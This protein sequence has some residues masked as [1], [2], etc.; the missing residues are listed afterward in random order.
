MTISIV[1]IS[2]SNGD[3]F[4]DLVAKANTLIDAMNLRTVTVDSNTTI[5]HAAIAGSL[6]TNT[7]YVST[8]TGGFKDNT[9][10]IEVTSNTSFVNVT[11]SGTNTTFAAIGNIR[12]PGGNVTHKTVLVDPATS[13]L[14]Y[15]D[16]RLEIIAIDGTG[17][18]IDSDLLDGQEG[19]WYADIPA[20]Q[21]YVSVNK[22]GD[23]ISGPLTVQG[24]TSLVNTSFTGSNTNFS[25]IGNIRIPGS[26]TTN[27]TV[28]VDPA[29][30]RLR[31]ADLREE[32]VAIDGA[33]SLIDSDLLDGQEGTWYTDIP[34]RQGYI[35]VNRAGDTISGALTVQGATTIANT[36]NIQSTVI[37]ANTT[38]TRIANTS[39]IEFNSSRFLSNTSLVTTVTPTVLHQFPKIAFSTVKYVISITNSTD[40]TSM[41]TE[42][43]VVSNAAANVVHTTQYATIS[44]NNIFGEFTANIAGANTQLTFTSAQTK[45]LTV[46]YTA[47]LVK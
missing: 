38:V 16:L 7:V 17:S 23:I 45:T 2:V 9:A 20:R 18:L 3:T 42:L 4:L 40:N 33:G 47:T 37:S 30:N 6:S 39:E 15:G 28:M 27:K 22:A 1:P 44:T 12:I 46:N 41:A 32:I 11:F 29:T 25:S 43:L 26:N 24:N 13:R 14:R 36:V 21:G 19:V 35:S 10:P 34:A 8:I 31:F 5:G